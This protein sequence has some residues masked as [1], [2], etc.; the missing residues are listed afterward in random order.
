MLEL[1]SGSG[2]FTPH[3]LSNHQ[4]PASG[5]GGTQ[6]VT[7]CRGPVSLP[8]HGSCSFLLPLV[9]SHTSFN[10]PF[11]SRPATLS[12]PQL[13]QPSYPYH[14][15]LALVILP[16]FFQLQLST[17][18]LQHIVRIIVFS[19]HFPNPHFLLETPREVL[20]SWFFSLSHF[21]MILSSGFFLLL[22][23][24]SFW[25]ILKKKT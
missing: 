19:N 25:Y 4:E 7:G 17:Q 18:K 22:S 14:H 20:V 9:Y 23:Y 8:E 15:H 12:S 13:T 24:I 2:C 10:S 1:W 6:R 3:Y 5:G 16:F 21:Y 11:Y